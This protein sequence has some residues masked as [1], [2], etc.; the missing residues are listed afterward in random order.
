MKMRTR[1]PLGSRG[2]IRVLPFVLVASVALSAAAPL[3]ASGAEGFLFG[4]ITTRSGTTYQGRLRWNEE[5]SWIDHFDA[6]KEW[7]ETARG[8]LRSGESEESEDRLL[9]RALRILGV[10][11]MEARG[12][13][14]RYRS[15]AR[16]AEWLD[17]LR[18][19]VERRHR[20]RVPSPLAR[21]A[22]AV[23]T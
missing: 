17:P 16:E 12:V 18:P 19:R 3:A 8:G 23:R 5:A 10:G 13:V 21:R 4:E 2:F 9:L 6:E 1:N 20:T 15:S 14:E 7:E 22:A 11:A